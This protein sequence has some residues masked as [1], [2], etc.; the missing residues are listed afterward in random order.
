MAGTSNRFLLTGA[1]A[2]LAAPLV[3]ARVLWP[4]PPGDGPW[5]LK[6]PLLHETG[7]P[8]PGCGATRAFVYFMHGDEGFLRYN[9][10]WLVIWAALLAWVALLVARTLRGAPLAGGRIR[11]M[12]A[13]LERSRAAAIALPFAVLAVPW[14]VALANVRWIS[15]Y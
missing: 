14:L 2:G 3:A 4:A 6:C 13:F 11:S 9:W 7:V 10:A 15:S 1:L 8:C 5:A 12:G